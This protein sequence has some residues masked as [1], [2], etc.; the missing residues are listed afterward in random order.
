MSDIA[1]AQKSRPSSMACDSYARDY[2]HNGSRQ[3]QVLG[4]GAAGS[5]L[6]AGIGAIAGAA[7]VG[8]AVGAGI[9]L[10]S[11]GARRHSDAERMYAA[12]YQDCLAGRVR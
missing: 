8:A 1:N 5:L 4:R 6:G 7:G 12:A 11:G 9:G 10:I 3:G 2:A